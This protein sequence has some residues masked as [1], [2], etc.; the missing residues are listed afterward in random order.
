MVPLAGE[1]QGEVLPLLVVIVATSTTSALVATTS[2]TAADACSS[3]TRTASSN[4]TTVPAGR[5]E[6]ARAV[7]SA[8]VAG[9]RTVHPGRRL[10]TASHAARVL[11]DEDEPTSTTKPPDDTW[12]SS[13]A[14]NG[15]GR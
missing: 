7:S 15:R 5:S 13:S 2:R 12:R 14:S 1:R 9:S 8:A 3:S 4:Q 11:P 10:R 6:R